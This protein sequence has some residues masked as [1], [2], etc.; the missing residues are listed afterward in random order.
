MLR[1]CDYDKDEYHENF[2]ISEIIV[3][4]IEDPNFFLCGSF[5]KFVLVANRQIILVCFK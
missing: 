5:L 3:S 4:S 1:L 2:S